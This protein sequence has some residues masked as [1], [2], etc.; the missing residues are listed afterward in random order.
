MTAENGALPRR[1]IKQMS[2]SEQ[3]VQDQ[4]IYDR[5]L[6]TALLELPLE[7]R[8]RIYTYALHVER[9]GRLHEE[10]PALSVNALCPPALL[11]TCRQIRHEAAPLHWSGH[12]FV[13]DTASNLSQPRHIGSSDG[14][15]LIDPSIG[16]DKDV[17]RSGTLGLSRSKMK[18]LRDPS[19]RARFMRIVLRMYRT[20]DMS[21]ARHRLRHP[22]PY[23]NGHLDN[24]CLGWLAE[25]HIRL[26]GSSWS[27]EFA[28]PSEHWRPIFASSAQ[29]VTDRWSDVVQSVEGRIKQELRKTAKGDII[30]RG[31]GIEHIARIAKLMGFDVAPV[32]ITQDDVERLEPRRT[33]AACAIQVGSR[34]STGIA[35][36]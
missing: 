1:N 17:M 15:R 12:A 24:A 33:H 13:F 4:D 18:L 16:R 10:P 30:G 19:L 20:D 6:S 35:H 26:R 32:R 7:L 9:T 22:R 29:S 5:T 11:Q 27:V 31:M 2:T 3:Q 34:E 14:Q 25:F 36:P 28:R 21:F 8:S 23:S